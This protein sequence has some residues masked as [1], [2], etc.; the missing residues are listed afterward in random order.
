M[1]KEH[2]PHTERQEID[3][4]KVRARTKR[5]KL[6]KKDYWKVQEIQNIGTQKRD[7]E[8]EI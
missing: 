4:K 3:C 8:I 1:E 6:K 5:K 2:D 7:F